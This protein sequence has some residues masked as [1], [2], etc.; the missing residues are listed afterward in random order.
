[1]GGIPFLMGAATLYFTSGMTFRCDSPTPGQVTCAEGR[2]FFKLIDV[3]VRRYTDVRG[4]STE[5]RMAYDEDG[6]SYE[7]AVT[8]FQIGSG[9]A[10]PLPA[11]EGVGLAGLSERVDEY[12][13]HPTPEGLRMAYDPGYPFFFF[14]LFGAFFVYLGL[15]NFFSYFWY[16]ADRFR[17]RA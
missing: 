7:K 15:W 2:R 10:E 12:A 13:K 14:H 17:A 8:V 5:K 1:M 4:A 16:L 3:P 6:N 11:G 9:R